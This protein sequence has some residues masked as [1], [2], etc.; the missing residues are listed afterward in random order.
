M[1]VIDAKKFAWIAQDRSGPEK[2]EKF[3]FFE[4]G[5]KKNRPHVGEFGPERR[6]KK[7]RNRPHV[8]KT[9]IWWPQAKK[10]ENGRERGL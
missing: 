7:T 8:T 4:T 2:I 6:P 5:C 1:G 3:R 9:E 10:C